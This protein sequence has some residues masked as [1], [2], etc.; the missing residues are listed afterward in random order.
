LNNFGSYCILPLIQAFKK[1]IKCIGSLF[2]P[3]FFSIIFPVIPICKL[4]NLDQRLG[5]DAK[6]VDKTVGKHVDQERACQSNEH[7]RA[8]KSKH[9]QHTNPRPQ[10]SRS[11][12]P[13]PGAC[14][15]SACAPSA[16]LPFSICCK[17]IEIK[18]FKTLI[19]SGS[20][21]KKS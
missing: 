6:R 12:R 5:D 16:V 17:M 20:N 1:S 9:I 21:E 3:N 14:S 4:Q 10:P 7:F 13:A 8:I 18:I 19:L 11:L 2:L 15:R